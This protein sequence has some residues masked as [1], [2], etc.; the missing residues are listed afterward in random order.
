MQSPQHLIRRSNI[1]SLIFCS[2]FCSLL[3]TACNSKQDI[4]A[5]TQN[6]PSAVADEQR[7]DSDNRAAREAWME[8]MHRAAPDVDWRRIEHRNGMDAM[9]RRERLLTGRSSA[10][11]VGSWL[12]V[13]SRNQAGRMHAST[14]SSDG[15]LLYAGS[16]LGGLWKAQPDGTQWTPLGD[17]LYGGAHQLAV[18]PQAGGQPDLLLVSDGN[19]LW[20]T[21]DEGLTWL[22]PGGLPKQ[23]IHRPLVLDDANHTV[24]VVAR[25]S[26]WGVWRSTDQ[27]QNFVKVRSLANSY[28][29]DLWTPR[30]RLD[31][32]YLFDNDQLYISQDAGLS[33]TPIGIPLPVTGPSDRAVL[34]CH[35]NPVIRTNVAIRVNG[36]WELWRSPGEGTSWTFRRN[37]DDF[38][39]PSLQASSVSGNLVVYGGVEVW[40][41]QNA[42]AGFQRV[43]SWTDYYGDPANHLHADI[44]WIAVYPDPQSP[45][46]EIWYI[47]TD[48]GLYQSLDRMDTVQNL[49]L[50]GLGV[51]QY[52]ST[53]TS[54]RNPEL[55]LAGSQDQ[56]YQRGVLGTPGG[57]GPYA[58]F[59][60][61]ISGDYG[62]LTSSNGAHDLVYSTYPGFIL[63][64]EGEDNPSILA[65]QDFPNGANHLWLPCV[66]A[67]PTDAEAFYFCGDRLYRYSRVSGRLWSST[68]HSAQDFGPGFITA[69]AFS[70]LDPQRAWIATDNGRLF[71]ST[72]GAV[73]WTQSIDTAPGSHYFYGT[74]LLPSARDVNVVWVGGSGY[75]SPPVKRSTDGGITWQRKRNQLPD[76][77]VYGLAEAPNGDGSIFAATQTGA[78]RFDPLQNAWEDIL[79]VDA[80]ITLYWSV[81][82]VPALNVIRFGTYGRGIWDYQ[83]DSPGY[84]P[85]GELLGGIN[86]LSLTSDSIPTIGSTNFIKVG[87]GPPLANGVLAHSDAAAEDPLYGG[88]ALI[89]QAGMQ[90][91]S[92]TTDVSGHAQVSISIPQNPALIG[93]ERFL[94][95]GIQD[96]TQPQGWLLSSALRARIGD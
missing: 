12:E 52:Y 57:V 80:P 1:P 50:T 83:L 70:P 37:L 6:G 13:G 43:N 16:S 23:G 95:A 81:E 60:Q 40:V 75:S 54:R 42:G 20:R 19:Q 35:E 34:A 77:L 22:S 62:H 89:S 33:F 88:V 86:R 28:R 69:L 64:Q 44:P 67:D 4:P 18:I 59:D 66:T 27:G 56:G 93:Q 36:I 5:P 94:Q 85:Y 73:T 65:G 31:A 29:A 47:G 3:A 2:V 11:A 55:L 74:A 26:Q 21:T 96:A 9:A 38:W 58:D 25:G 41:S 45:Q 76:T 72:D 49:S 68:Q 39:E 8:A 90:T 51:S 63:I 61:L 7:E 87:N 48:G 32:V 71:Y 82:A 46:G 14:P 91:V 30:D 15:S 92:F 78:W 79:G 17:N 24:L 10:P 53:H 84:F